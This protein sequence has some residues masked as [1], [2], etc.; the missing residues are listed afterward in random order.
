MISPGSCGK[1]TPLSDI[2][3]SDGTNFPLLNRKRD[4]KLLAIAHYGKGAGK[5]QKGDSPLGR[6]AAVYRPL[7][8]RSLAGAIHQNHLHTAEKVGQVIPRHQL[9]SHSHLTA[10]RLSSVSGR[11][12]PSAESVWP[13]SGKPHYRCSLST[14]G[15]FRCCRAGR[16]GANRPF[17]T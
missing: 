5:S 8:D 9:D 4:K 11:H 3:R 16:G 7:H 2:K 17:L 6:S 10:L 13:R 1:W 14:L 15:D 12:M